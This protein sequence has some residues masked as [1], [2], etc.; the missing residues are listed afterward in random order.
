MLERQKER[1]RGTGQRQNKLLEMEED[2]TNHPTSLVQEA[3]W[4]VQEGCF[5]FAGKD[6]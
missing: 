5:S 4:F 6:A 3:A 1:E 2:A